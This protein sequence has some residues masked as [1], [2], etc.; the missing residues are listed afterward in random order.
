M[1]KWDL[2]LGCKDHLTW[3]ITKLIYHLNR[4]KDKN[5]MIISID[6]EKHFDEN[7]L[8]HDKNSQQTGYKRNTLQYNKFMCEKPIANIIF[9]GK[10]LKVFPQD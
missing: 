9:N 1:T 6:A 3:H 5:H 8:F 7:T 4:M 2:S 10:R